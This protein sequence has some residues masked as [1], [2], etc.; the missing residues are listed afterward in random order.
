[1][2]PITSK[3]PGCHAPWVTK[4]KNCYC[5]LSLLGSHINTEEPPQGATKV[6]YSYVAERTKTRSLCSIYAARFLTTKDCGS[7]WLFLSLTC[8]SQTHK[9]VYLNL[10][11][12][13]SFN[14]QK[15]AHQRSSYT[16]LLRQLDLERWC[17]RWCWSATAAAALISTAW[18]FRHQR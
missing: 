17:E 10:T 2:C 7:G 16:P 6:K 12:D 18:P 8:L 5:Y 4:K 11:S 15:T 1:M 3:A 14:S 13:V 9:H